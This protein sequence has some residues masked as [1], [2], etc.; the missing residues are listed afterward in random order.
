MFSCLQKLHVNHWRHVFLST[1]NTNMISHFNLPGIWFLKKI[2]FTW[3]KNPFRVKLSSLQ[4]LWEKKPTELQHE[5]W[6]W[7]IS[8]INPFFSPLFLFYHIKLWFYLHH[9]KLQKKII[10]NVLVHLSILITFKQ[11]IIIFGR[12]DRKECQN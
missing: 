6:R 1:N 10:H 2:C 9:V 8:N 4:N 12:D 11:S 5:Y 7:I 3:K